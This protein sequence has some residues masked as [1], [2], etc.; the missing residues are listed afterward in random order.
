[1]TVSIRLRGF[2]AFGL[3]TMTLAVQAQDDTAQELADQWMQAYN[4]HDGEALAA[5]YTEDAHLY[6]H[7]S[8]MIAGRES[9][10][11][12]WAQDFTDGN[13]LTLLTVT[14]YVNGFDMVLVHGN[15]Q[16]VDRDDGSQLG[17]GR[18]AH[19]WHSEGGGEWRLH[20]DLW[21]QPVVDAA[22]E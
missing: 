9:I 14:N 15:Y 6:V 12:F 11:A 4:L 20:S 17:F 22:F 18:F 2:L 1:M 3:V 7:G 16:V 19:I 10:E 8:P 13:P 5:L 21:N